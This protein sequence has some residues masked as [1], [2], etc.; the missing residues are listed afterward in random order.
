MGN[1]PAQAWTRTAILI[2]GERGVIAASFCR[3]RGCRLA[4]SLLS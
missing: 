4:S 2:V 3:R 1:H